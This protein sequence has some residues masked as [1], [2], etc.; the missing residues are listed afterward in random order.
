LRLG[1]WGSLAPP[2]FL[3]V[4]GVSG[5]GAFCR[6]ERAGAGHAGALARP[7]TSK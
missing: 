1:V 3:L 4:S 2:A 6:A 7:A 5:P